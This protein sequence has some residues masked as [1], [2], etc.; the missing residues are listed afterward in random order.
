M[1]GRCVVVIVKGSSILEV[2]FW[3]QVSDL[4]SKEGMGCVGSTCSCRGFYA[5]IDRGVVWSQKQELGFPRLIYP[6]RR[7][8][9]RDIRICTKSWKLVSSRKLRFS[10]FICYAGLH[11][12]LIQRV[13]ME[14]ET[15]SSKG[16]CWGAT[17]AESTFLHIKISCCTE[18][19]EFFALGVYFYKNM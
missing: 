19:A 16:T 12:L 15:S 17:H 3:L 18:L 10:N 1:S 7:T 13:A 5:T 6:F 9:L 4:Y 11:S 8:L 2:K 14:M